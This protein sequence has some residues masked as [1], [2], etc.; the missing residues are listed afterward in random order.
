MPRRRLLLAI[1]LIL[2]ALALP[3]SAQAGRV[4]TVEGAPGPNPARYD[5]VYVE[6]FGRATAGRVLVLVPGVYAGAGNFA[7]VADELVRRVPDLQVWAYDRRSEQFEDHSVFRDG[8]PGEALS[9]YLPPFTARGRTFTP[10]DGSS[11]P[12]ARRWGL[13]LALEDLRRVIRKARDGGRRKVVLGGHSLGA[14]MAAAYATWDFGGRAGYRDLEGLVFIDG[15]ALGSSGL[16]GQESLAAVRTRLAELERGSPFS[17]LLGLGVPFAA[18]A[19]VEIGAKLAIEQRDQPSALQQYPL[20]PA[21]FRP[22]IP[23]TNEGIFGHAFDKDTGP[24]Q[25]ALIRVNAGR[26][27][28]DGRWQDGQITPIQRLARSF[29][30]PRRLNGAEWYFPERLSIDL[31]A[32]GGLEPSVT[33]RFLGLRPRHL[34]RVDRP[35]Y[36]FQT[37]LAR[38]RVLRAARAFIRHS[39][40]P[41]GRSTLVDR[42]G[43]TSHVDPLAGAP[44]RND[45]L[46]TVV[47]FLKSL[48]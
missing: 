35:V 43:T 28:A 26:L 24:P 25:L 44:G 11:A 8:T 38:G 31:D 27:G 48:A 22:P 20:L 9:Y 19:F 13:P 29:Y 33:T 37:D 6:R 14:S 34:A 17:D 12:F 15:V 5:K 2:G 3:A 36:A 45:F 42:A 47:P 23:V 21:A 4:V 46:K 32:L 10:V 7:L 39:D 41:R 18:Q 1:S 30:R 40:V 16:P